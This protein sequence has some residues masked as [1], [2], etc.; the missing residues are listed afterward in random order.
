MLAVV[1]AELVLSEQMLHLEA[2]VVLVCLIV[3]AVLLLLMR[4]EGAAGQLLQ[5]VQAAQEGA[6][7][8]QMVRVLE[9]R[10]QQIRAVVVAAHTA[11][12]LQLRDH[13]AV[14][15][16]S[17]FPTQAHNVAQAA[18]SHQAVA[19]PSIHLQQVELLRHDY[20]RAP[21]TAF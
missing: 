7:R 17:S 4:V 19:T 15:A 14:Q 6:E 9:L 20:A 18:Q 16:L 13:R 11:M 8:E 5:A 12:V 2:Q 10:L 21:E 1:V 3:L